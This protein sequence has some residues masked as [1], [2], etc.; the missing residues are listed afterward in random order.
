MTIEVRDART[1][2]TEHDI[3]SIHSRRK[4]K[5]L[6]ETE[7]DGEKGHYHAAV[8]RTIGDDVTN[9]CCN[10]FAKSNNL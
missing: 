10:W 4:S 3:M 9:S 5:S 7:T 2:E 1:D 8:L 6:T